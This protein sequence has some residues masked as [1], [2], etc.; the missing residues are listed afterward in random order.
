M[1]KE[2]RKLLFLKS[3]GVVIGEI[4][5]DTDASVL[6]LTK[7]NVKTVEMDPDTEYWIGDF[8]SGKVVSKI[9][10]PLITEAM[11][12]YSSNVKALTEY[13]IHKQLNIMIDM[14]DKSSLEKTTEFAKM[15]EF[16]DSIRQEH[17]EKVEFYANNPET[18]TWLSENEE[19]AMNSKKVI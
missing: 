16:L 11:V 5:N 8:N 4:T 3:T 13:P 10:K 18:Y 12:K 17:K 15:K 19:L 6:D 7:F 2:I 1:A 14:L 9:E